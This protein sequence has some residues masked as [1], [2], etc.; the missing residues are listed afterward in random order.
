MY[1]LV[2]Y[3][4]TPEEFIGKSGDCEDYAIVKM[5]ALLQVGFKP[6]NMRVV[7]IKDK[8]RNID[9]AILAV[10]IGDEVL[11][12]DNTSPLVL[13]HSKYG[14]YRPVVSFNLQYK[15]AHVPPSQ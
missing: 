4:A 15:W 6:E 2:D 14:H 1:G 10:Y 8:I 5:F 12:L 3:W 9:H 13:P 7:I 11:V